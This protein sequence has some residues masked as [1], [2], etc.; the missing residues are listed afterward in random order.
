[1]LTSLTQLLPPEAAQILEV[2]FLSFLLGLEREEH[3]A[4]S[5]G[6]TF[7]GVRTFP[8]IGLMGFGLGVLDPGPGLLGAG[9]LSLA[10]L[11]GLSYAH[12]LKVQTAAGAT[13]ELSGLCVYLVGGLVARQHTWLACAVVVATLLLLELKTALEGLARRIPSGEVITFAKFLFL[14][15][16]ILPVV[17]NQA[18]TPFLV[19]PYK[20]WLVVVAV[21]T[22]SYGGYLLERLTKGRAGIFL[23]ALLGGAY[24]STVTTVVL[25]KRSVRETAPQRFAGGILAASGIMYLRLA[26]L[27]A[28]FNGALGRMLAPSLLALGLVGVGAGWLVSRRGDPAPPGEPPPESRNPLDLKAAF[29]FASI[30]LA[31]LVITR[32]A[33]EHLGRGGLY[34]LATLMG[35]SDVDPFIMG[36][37][38]TAGV[39]TPLHEAAVG[40]LVAAASNNVIKGLYARS[41]GSRAAGNRALVLLIALAALGLA[42]VALV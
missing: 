37:T 8:L 23:S 40:V 22:V 6:Y 21:S 25:A 1:M 32:L 42:A 3:K 4:E 15:A 31:M 17:P 13:T 24:S 26:V 36:L 19:N 7:G 5:T 41:F 35:V 2:L 27:V 12:K 30:F 16:V 14:A 9:L 11:L 38:Q 39:A 28:L 18:F 29:L 33:A 34:G 20:T 10:V